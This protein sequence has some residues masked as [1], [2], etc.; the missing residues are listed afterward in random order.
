MK[1]K[2][3]YSCVLLILL[4]S[5]PYSSLK[6]K[7]PVKKITIIL[8]AKH[9]ERLD[10]GA[11]KL[12]SAL[13]AVGYTVVTQQAAKA[14]VG[15][16]IVIGLLQDALIKTAF[17]KQH[18][19][20]GK[21][22]GKEGFIINGINKS[23]IVAGAD[24]SGALYGCLELAE[25]IRNNKGLPSKLA[26]TD[27]PE[28]VL[29]GAC[30]GVQKPALLP[31]R[32]VYEYPYTP[33]NFPWF[34][35]KALWLRYLDSLAEN[36][37]NSLYL[38]NGHPFASLVKVKEYPY[39]VEVD[40]A[41]FKRNEDIYHFLASEAD[42]RGIWLIQGFYNIIVSKPF[43]EKNNLKTQDRN[44]HIV[45]IIADY[46]RKSIAAFVQKYP[47]VGLLITLGEAMEGVGQDDTEWFT[48]T[49]IPGVQDGLKALGRTDE[50]PIVL[51]A[52][53][54]DA[55]TVMKYAQPLYK[56]LYTMAKYN[57][58]ALTTY[59]PHGPWADLHR[60]LSRIGTVQIENVHILANLEPFRYGSADF[61]QKCVLAM[62]NAYGANG[63]HIYPQ[64]SYWDWP[65]TADNSGN[66]R[67]LQIDRDWIWY[68]EWARYAWNCHRDRKEEINYWANQLAAKYGSDAAHGRDILKAY[69]RSGEIAPE[70]LRR[71]G[72]TDGNRQTMTLGMLMSQLV[73][74]EKFGLFT[75]LYNSEG[76][77]G[78][79]MS[80]YAE[81]EWK[82]LPH[83]GETPVKVIDSVIAQGR[84]AIEAANKA[85]AGVTKDKVEFNRF[86][87]DMY[88]YNALANNYA[89]KA[90]AA[91]WV[92]R[93]KYS[94][95]VADLEKA[96]PELQ[97]SLK[98]F[99]ELVDLTKNTYLYANSMQTKQRKIPVGGNDAKMKTWVELLP[100]YQKELDNFKRNIDSLRSPQAT[101]KKT[102][103][104]VLTDA[105]V[106]IPSAGYYKLT[107]GEQVF[108]DTT[109]AIKN[110]APELAGLKAIKLNK[111][112]QLKNGTELSF[113]SSKPVK[114]LVGFFSTKDAGYSPEPQLETDASAND[115]GQADTKIA[116]AIQIEGMPPVN[117]HAYTFKAGSNTLTLGK[118]ACLI[119]GIVDDKAYIPVYDAGL[120]NSGNIKDLRWLFN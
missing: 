73:N 32:G 77:V 30:V 80:E 27:E 12:R 118:G 98:Y 71:F 15:Q 68:K 11:Q 43:A 17:L 37:M 104:V 5:C 13:Q 92:L 23:V 76:P 75:L 61:I 115:Y 36:R 47:N 96:L 119:L 64:A 102:E 99:K 87:N 116:N 49:I 65:Y 58:E 110:V 46:T 103:K 50:P 88:C 24:N 74:P 107:A 101:S 100:V 83:I 18:T 39:A 69:E 6:A 33:Q 67:L 114:V 42:K 31:G 89:Y 59:E 40:D 20:I 29:R 97:T 19:A 41:T 4:L 72:I 38:W 35:D 93:Y 79:M 84:A 7:E 62:H 113:T 108:A 95:N 85:S 112:N 78:E 54:S 120:S 66:S 57:G 111:A 52:H 25:R 14:A 9:H 16:S 90:K 94:D 60:T 44:R 105:A 70:L 86:K 45:P 81:K 2:I 8:P 91:L 63:L 48:K 56:N 55:P 26:I 106:N 22:P 34:Y 21:T 109:V 117:V 1:I 3:S 82:H 28:M 51:R 10:Y 53:D